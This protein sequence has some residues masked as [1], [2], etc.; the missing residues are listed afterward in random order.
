MM[1]FVSILN[2]TIIRMVKLFDMLRSGKYGTTR[3]RHRW[4]TQRGQIHD[5]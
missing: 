3:N 2:Y 1:K 4:Q 5:I